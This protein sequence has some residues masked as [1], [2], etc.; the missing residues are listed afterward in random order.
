MPLPGRAASAELSPCAW[1]LYHTICP[2]LHV[3]EANAGTELAE[4]MQQMTTRQ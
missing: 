2:G 1:E 3:P 4:I